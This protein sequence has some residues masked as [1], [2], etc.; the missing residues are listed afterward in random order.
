M[1]KEQKKTAEGL[2]NRQLHWR[3]VLLLLALALLP[4]TIM[5]V[6]YLS[7]PGRPTLLE[8]GF[9]V[10]EHTSV[11]LEWHNNITGTTRTVP[12]EAEPG[13]AIRVVVG[14]GRPEQQTID[15]LF[16]A[17]M[18][19]RDDDV[20]HIQEREQVIKE[21]YGISIVENK[22]LPTGGSRF[23]FRYM[24]ST[25]PL[26]QAL[27]RREGLDTVV[28]GVESE[29]D[30]FRALLV[31]VRA[32]APAGV[33]NPYPRFNALEILDMTRKGETKAFCGQYAQVLVQ[34][35]ISLGYQARYVGLESHEVLE[36]WSNDYV[37]W[38]VLDP[39]NGCYYRRDGAPL[40]ALELHN[41]VCES[42]LDE[43]E[44]VRLDP[45]VQ[46]DPR[47]QLGQYTTF[48][49]S[50]VNDHPEQGR[51]GIEDVHSMWRRRVYWVDQYTR[52]LPVADGKLRLMTS[53]ES[54]IYFNINTVN[55]RFRAVAP[56]V[57]LVSLES[58]TP[59]LD[60][61][62]RAGDDGSWQR[63]ADHFEW[64]LAEGANVLRL[65]A[66]N[67]QGVVGPVSE[68][69]VRFEVGCTGSDAIIK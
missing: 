55:A 49:V 57:V 30:R 7:W 12:L 66:V 32:T 56:G 8:D 51:S 44:T 2:F 50:M 68:I 17:G 9:V 29:F 28:S 40:N 39:F 34:S 20:D 43:I 58:F 67:V 19:S 59:E 63:V 47:E 69:T 64:R 33:P 5:S 48:N 22:L 14:S 53:F 27:R 65:R 18:K 6:V 24:K 61:L 26:M 11:A 54:D 41:L 36:V 23:R 37:K 25:S 35:L 52:K 60:H 4:M 46:R 38:V 45:E 1:T 42:R 16:R 15:D 3:S 21:G 13:Q 62:E 10:P 31:W